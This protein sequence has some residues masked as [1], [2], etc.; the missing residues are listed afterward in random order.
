ME[1]PQKWPVVWRDN[2]HGNWPKVASEQLMQ[3]GASGVF[4]SVVRWAPNKSMVP[5]KIIFRIFQNWKFQNWKKLKIEF[6]QKWFFNENFQNFFL[7]LWPKWPVVLPLAIAMREAETFIFESVKNE[8]KYFH[9]N[10]YKQLHFFT[11]RMT[12]SPWNTGALLLKV[13]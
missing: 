13:S 2:C 12:P 8:V 3:N 7:S 4:I 1:P 5:A 11:C 9:Y 10:R 6:F